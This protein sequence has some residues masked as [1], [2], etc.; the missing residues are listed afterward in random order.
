MGGCPKG[1]Y[2]SLPIHTLDVPN[3]G[4]GYARKDRI[5]KAA[6]FGVVN[7]A[8]S[9]AGA[10]VSINITGLSGLPSNYAVTVNP[11]QDATWFVSNKTS[12]G[13]TITLNPR[14]ATNTL[15]AGAID[16]TLEG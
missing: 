6:A 1:N 11:G 12:T 4:N 7:A 16:W 10:S 9:G 13:F 2:M 14:L 3:G 5:F 8:G 15:A